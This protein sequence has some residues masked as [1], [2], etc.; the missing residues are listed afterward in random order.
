[1]TDRLLLDGPPE[2]Y[3][4]ISK[5]RLQIDGVDDLEEWRLLKVSP[6]RRA[7]SGGGGGAKD[8]AD[9]LRMRYTSWGSQRRSSSSSS[10]Y[11][12]SSSISAT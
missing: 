11:P 4:F 1:V 3:Q 5:T 2:K 9:R 10:A 7:E 6:A 8:A 12:L